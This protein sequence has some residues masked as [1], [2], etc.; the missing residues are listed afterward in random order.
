MG[1]DDLDKICTEINRIK[2][3]I[4]LISD[5]LNGIAAYEECTNE[6]NI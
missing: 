2:E 5:T 4:S 6:K 3:I 1:R